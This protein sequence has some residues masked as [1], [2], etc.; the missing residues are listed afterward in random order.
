M[1][2]QKIV[3]IDLKKLIVNGMK[4]ECNS[5]SI[6]NLNRLEMYSSILE[7]VYLK[8]TCRLVLKY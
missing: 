4:L 6:D 7:E 8:K 2:T 3:E 1:Q 5:K